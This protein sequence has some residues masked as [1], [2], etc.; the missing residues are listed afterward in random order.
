M[1]ELR[2]A[3]A[4]RQRRV[5]V[6][7]DDHEVRALLLEDRLEPLHHLG[8]LLRVA[9]G[10]DAE[11]VVGLRQPELLEEDLGH[12]PVVVLPGV[13]DRARPSGKRSRSAA[14]TGAI[15]TRLGRV[16]TT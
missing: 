10:A 7:G 12:Q 6:A 9:A 13:D 14:I 8:D 3:S 15:L 16:P 11:Q 2:R 1:P 4:A 5:D